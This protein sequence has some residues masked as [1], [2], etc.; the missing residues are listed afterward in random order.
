MNHETQITYIR[1]D[2]KGNAKITTVG[3]SAKREVFII[4]GPITFVSVTYRRKNKPRRKPSR[5]KDG[6]KG[7]RGVLRR[8]LPFV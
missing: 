6:P 5:Q 7:I 4:K 3:W 8:C 2:K 1:R